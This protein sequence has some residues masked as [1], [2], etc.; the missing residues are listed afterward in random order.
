MYADLNR[1]LVGSGQIPLNTDDRRTT[2]LSAA[3]IQLW[4][5]VNTQHTTA[6]EGKWS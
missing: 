3:A 5:S 4:V 2:A 6:L 1:L